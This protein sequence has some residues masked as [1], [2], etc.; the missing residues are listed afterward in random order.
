MTETAQLVDAFD[1]RV[2]RREER[3]D[4][5][6][7]ALG[8]AAVGAGGFVFASQAAAQSVTDNDILN[9]ALNLEYLEAQFYSYAF[10]GVGLA[11]NLLTGSGQQGAVATSATNPPRAVNFTGDPLIRQY[12][13]EIFEDERAHV[14][15]LRAALTS[16]TTTAFVAQPAININGDA[17]GPFTAAANSVGI[18]LTSRGGV[19]DPYASP[20]DFLL[21]SYIFEDVGVTAYKGSSALIQSNAFLDA[22]AGILATEA[23]HSGI[24][25]GSLYARGVAL[26]ELRTFADKLSDARD[27]VDGTTTTSATSTPQL[28]ADDDQGIS[29]VQLPL[30]SSAGTT[31]A[32][33]SNFV[34]T[35]AN[36]IT[37]S[38]TAQQVLNVVYL[39]RAAVTLGGFFPNGVNGTI[40][41]SAAN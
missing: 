33:A 23:F 40:R 41:T 35:D 20:N 31:T 16:G 25:R 1:A 13:R 24:I 37:F 38:R 29:P 15:F 6:K 2:R 11:A 26:P 5:F 9:F 18:D 30:T 34:P 10:S 3:R 32:T 4:F 14:A 39:N 7:A 8:V 22:A 27:S 12:A 21:G 17:A 36:G 28:F 19:F